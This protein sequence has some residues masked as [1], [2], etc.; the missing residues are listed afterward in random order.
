MAASYISM[1]TA[2]SPAARDAIAEHVASDSLS[3]MQKEER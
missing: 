1:L 2:I 3:D